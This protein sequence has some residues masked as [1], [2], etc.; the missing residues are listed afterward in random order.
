[1]FLKSLNTKSSYVFVMEILSQTKG[2]FTNMKR[3]IEQ[4]YEKFCKQ[5]F[6]G[7]LG[8]WLA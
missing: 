6:S 8:V 7:I 3:K 1:M 5:M 4:I 2:I